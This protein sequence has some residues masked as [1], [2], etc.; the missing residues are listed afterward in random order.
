[1][2][3]LITAALGVLALA[4]LVI[5]CGGGGS[6]EATAQVSKVQFY[7]EAR[8]ICAD[9]QKKFRTELETSKDISVVYRKAGPLLEHEAE[10]LEA[11]VGPEAV[12]EEVKPL[13]AK[14][15]K[16]SHRIAQDGEAAANDPSTQAYK[17]EAAELKLR[18]C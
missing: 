5:G 10:E 14:V 6:D 17:Q 18:E 9:V 11:I 2:N 12:E 13:I 3:R 4:L 8:A 16:A 1:M 7:K 15:V